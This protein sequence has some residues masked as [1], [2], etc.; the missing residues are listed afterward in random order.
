MSLFDRLTEG[1]MLI[2]VLFVCV[3][4]ILA[5]APVIGQI[6]GSGYEALFELL[7]VLVLVGGVVGYVRRILD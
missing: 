1:F 2:V 4:V 7:A 3:V 5:M 6:G